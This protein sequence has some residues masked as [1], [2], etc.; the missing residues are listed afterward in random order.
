MTFEKVKEILVEELGLDDEVNL[1]DNLKD[2]LDADSLDLA[3]VV[4]NLEEA[5]DIEIPEEDYPKF[6]TV[7]DIVDFIDAKKN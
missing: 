6:V 1:T 4:I 5:F 2:D 3:E 7:K